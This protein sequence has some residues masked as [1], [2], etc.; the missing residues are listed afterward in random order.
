MGN[1]NAAMVLGKCELELKV[2]ICESAIMVDLVKLLE[3]WD[4]WERKYRIP[5]AV[6]WKVLP[7]WWV[8]KL[9][10]WEDRAWHTTEVPGVAKS[11][12]HDSSDCHLCSKQGTEEWF[13][14]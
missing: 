11:R 1:L 13:Q 14:N 2:K 4:Y 3:Y 7:K 5:K 10:S 6:L 9:M 8:K 12:W